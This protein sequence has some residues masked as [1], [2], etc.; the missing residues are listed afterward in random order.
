MFSE[1]VNVSKVYSLSSRELLYTHSKMWAICTEAYDGVFTSEVDAKIQKVLNYQLVDRSKENNT[2]EEREKFIDIFYND[3]L[4]NI[5]VTF[6]QPMSILRYNDEWINLLAELDINS[7]IKETLS[8]LHGNESGLILDIVLDANG[9]TTGFTTSGMQLNTAYETTEL[10]ELYKN[11]SNNPATSDAV[12]F[13]EHK[14]DSDNIIIHTSRNYSLK[15]YSFP[16]SNDKESR[17]IEFN[18]TL[19]KRDKQEYVNYW[20]SNATKFNLMTEDDSIWIKSLI[21]HQMQEIDLSF[22]FDADKTL[23]DVLVYKR[24]VKE[25]KVW[26]A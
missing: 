22:V 11:M 14:K 20:L 2:A 8:D 19:I 26:R 3:V 5:N 23:I 15:N 25:F 18:P 13:I 9:N 10:G 7:D 6:A 21:D 16:S 4:E 12:M 17:I 24:E 1:E